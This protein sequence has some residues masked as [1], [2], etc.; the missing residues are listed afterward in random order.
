MQIQI[1]TDFFP[2]IPSTKKERGYCQ[3][4][5]QLCKMLKLLGKEGVKLCTIAERE[6]IPL[7]TVY[8]W[9]LG[10]SFPTSWQAESLARLLSFRFQELR[11]YKREKKQ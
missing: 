7:A 1:P 5:A 9:S 2:E 3:H 10:K 6:G 4:K 11:K 8:R